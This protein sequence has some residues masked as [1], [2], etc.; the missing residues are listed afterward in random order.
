MSKYNLINKSSTLLLVLATIFTVG[1][2][3]SL[4]A[5]ETDSN[6]TIE[7]IA[8]EDNV[9]LGEEVT[10]RGEVTEVEPGMSFILQEEGL[11]EGD[12]V[13]VINVS[14]QMLPEQ[15]DNLELQVTGE[16]GMLVVADVEQEYGLELNPEFYV[17][18][19]NKPVI[20]ASSM[21]LSPEIEDVAENPDRYYTQEIAVKGEVKNINSD[22]AFILRE[23]KLFSDDNLLIVNTTG[24]PI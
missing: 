16:K 20:F 15:Q 14:Q 2:Y 18:Y 6:V 5:Q 1:Q 4:Q 7:D 13:L 11:F 23:D 22:Y 8:E 17:D 3:Q 19:E 21:V 12:E 24:E 9:A 10:V